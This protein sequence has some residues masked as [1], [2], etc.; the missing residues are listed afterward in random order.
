[1]NNSIEQDIAANQKSVILKPTGLCN[2]KCKFC[3]ASNFSDNCRSIESFDVKFKTYIEKHDIQNV[4]LT[5]GEITLVPKF[6]EEI[7]TYADQ[8]N[9]SVSLVSNMIEIINHLDYWQDFFRKHEKL[10][11]TASYQTDSQRSDFVGKKISET[12]FTNFAKWYRKELDKR[13][14]VISVVND[15]NEN[16]ILENL[17]LAKECKYVSSIER[18]IGIGRAKYEYSPLKY[19]KL[20]NKILDIDMWQYEKHLR[21]LV[22][23]G[24]FSVHYCNF[25]CKQMVPVIYIDKNDNLI[26]TFCDHLS[27]TKFS[28]RDF[29]HEKPLK[30]ECAFCKYQNLCQACHITRKNINS[31]INNGQI[32]ISIYC[33]ELKNELK[34]LENNI[35]QIRGKNGTEL[36]YKLD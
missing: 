6:L 8:N 26:E 1:M 5:G 17:Q 25:Y 31:Q 32:D 29:I 14:L 21:L 28:Y 23:S 33:E 10:H 20:L 30:K 34:K 18:Q 2:A 27:T 36:S 9:I 15:E 3:Y 19:F 22:Q 7:C 13:L 11:L 24:M 16:R 12:D 4:I 35:L